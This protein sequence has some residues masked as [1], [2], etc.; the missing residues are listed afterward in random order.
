MKATPIVA[1]AI[2]LLL[3]AAQSLAIYYDARHGAARYRGEIATALSVH[4]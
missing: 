3:T 2:G 4:R 1:L